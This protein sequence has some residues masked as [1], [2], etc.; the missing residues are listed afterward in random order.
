MYLA[1]HCPYNTL[2]AFILHNLITDAEAQHIVDLAW[3][4]MQGGRFDEARAHVHALYC[5]KGCLTFCRQS[6]RSTCVCTGARARTHAHTYTHTY[7]HAPGVLAFCDMQRSTV[8][9]KDGTSVLDDYRWIVGVLDDYRWASFYCCHLCTVA[10][11]LSPEQGIV[12]ESTNTAVQLFRKKHPVSVIAKLLT[13]DWTYFADLVHLN[14]R[15]LRNCYLQGWC[16]LI[17]GTAEPHPF[18]LSRGLGHT[19][20]L[21][22]V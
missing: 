12:G 21:L 16:G 19:V 8:V 7:T 18:I 22:A 17:H 15:T 13:I 6:T 3:P 4:Q 14:S 9:G 20:L 10:C 5:K 2:R 1:S 11:N